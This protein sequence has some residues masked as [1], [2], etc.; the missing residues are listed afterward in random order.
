MREHDESRG[1]GGHGELPGQAH[2]SHRRAEF[3]LR[4]VGARRASAGARRGRAFEQLDDLV[5]AGLAEVGVGLA[6]GEE[7]RRRM[8]AD[9]LIGG[10]PDPLRDVLR[11][12]RYR[13][14][15][16]AAPCARAT[17]HAARAV[18]PVAIP[19]ST[20]TTVRPASGTRCT[21]AAERRA[22]CCSSARSRSRPRRVPRR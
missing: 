16:L 11:A 19:S 14:H 21:P 22:R 15:T 1:A 12:D 8:Q 10:R 6:D 3:L 18:E 2:P 20:T 13:Q 5:V 4:R 17:W 7:V 9:H